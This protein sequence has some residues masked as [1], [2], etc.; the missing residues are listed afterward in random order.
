MIRI[1]FPAQ[2]AVLPTR[3]TVLHQQK[4]ERH[5]GNVQ[6]ANQLQPQGE[7]TGR[8]Q[9]QIPGRGVQ[10]L[11]LIELVREDFLRPKG[12]DCRQAL[13]GRVR[14][15]E[16]GTACCREGEM[17]VGESVVTLRLGIIAVVRTYSAPPPV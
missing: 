1:N 8:R 12:P 11:M 2:L 4:A 16:N 17:L 6:H 9:K 3:L 14:V 15:R 5:G 7:G 13:E 10:V